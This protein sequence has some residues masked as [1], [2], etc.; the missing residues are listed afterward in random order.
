MYFVIHQHMAPFHFHTLIYANSVYVDN[1]RSDFEYG[2]TKGKKVNKV[3]NFLRG[4]PSKFY[5]F[6]GFKSLCSF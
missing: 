4:K 3:L 2:I 1:G 6:N 5:H